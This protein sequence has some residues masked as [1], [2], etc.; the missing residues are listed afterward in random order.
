MAGSGLSQ[1]SGPFTLLRLESILIW[2]C[3]LI[4]GGSLVAGRLSSP[5][6]GTHV[7]DFLVMEGVTRMRPALG[8]HPPLSVMGW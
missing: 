4:A 7:E 1:L 8:C 3:D 6:R 2:I 5:L